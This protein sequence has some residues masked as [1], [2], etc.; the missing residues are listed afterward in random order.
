MS[1]GLMIFFIWLG[2][3]LLVSFGHYLFRKAYPYNEGDELNNF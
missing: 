2:V 3:A 1:T